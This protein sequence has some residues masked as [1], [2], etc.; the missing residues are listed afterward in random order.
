[1]KTAKLFKT[2]RSRA[3]RIPKSWIEGVDEV[4]LEKQDDKII[5]HP[6]K[7]DLWQVAEECRD[8]YGFPERLPQTE[9]GIRVNFDE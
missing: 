1:M 4:F 8:E 3:I 2:G 7:R 9:T 5:I 6:K